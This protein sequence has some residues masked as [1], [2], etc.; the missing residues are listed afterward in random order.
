MAQDEIKSTMLYH[1]KE[2]GE[3]KTYETEE[4]ILHDLHEAAGLMNQLFRLLVKDHG[5]RVELELVSNH[6]MGVGSYP[7]LLARYYREIR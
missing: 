4:E 6:E 1:C 3:R 7:M 5:I 2:L